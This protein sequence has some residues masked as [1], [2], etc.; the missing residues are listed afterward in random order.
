MTYVPPSSTTEGVA[1]DLRRTGF[2]TE[3]ETLDDAVV[4]RLHGELDMAT[5]PVLTQ[6][7]TDAIDGRG[8]AM[9]VDLAS[10]R[11]MDSTGIAVLLA[12]GRLADESGCAF[13][14][15]SPRRP[16]LKALRLTGVDRILGIDSEDQPATT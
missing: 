9:V 11:F 13:V 5:S 6:A 16:V 3:V 10:L 2:H 4:L 14:V 7:F 8:K 12:A 15:R 1:A